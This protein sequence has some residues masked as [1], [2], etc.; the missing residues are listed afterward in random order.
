MRRVQQEADD[1]IALHL[2]LR[3]AQLIAEGM[4]PEHARAEA[5]RRFGSI[6][7]E[8]GRFRHVARRR[9]SRA[10]TR[11]W[12]D[13]VVQDV[14]Y[15]LRTLRRDAGFSLF[16]TLIL[17]LGIGA[18]ATVFSLVNAVLLEPLPFRDPSRLV[19]ISNVGD[20][21]VAEWRLQV[22]HFLDLAAR[23][24]S[25]AGIAGYFAYYGIGDAALS[26]NGATERL[27]RV[28]V[29]CNFFPFLGVTP[30]I[31]R[32]FS[33]EECRFGAPSTV[34]LTAQL[35]RERFAS[36]RSVVG[37]TI[38][39][40][41]A[42][43]TII[44]VLPPAF[45]FGSVFAPGTH[46]DL[47]G[48]YALSDETNRNG[49][50]LA[51]VGRLA[52]GVTVAQASRELVALGTSLTAEF[53]QR[54]T[55]R[56][57]VV[58]LDDR[59]NGKVRPAFLVLASAVAAV[60]LIVMVNLAS[61]QFARMSARQ[62]ELAVRVAL[63]AGRGRLVRQTLTEILMLTAIGAIAGVLLA[64]VGTHLVSRLNAFAIPLLGRTE[65]NGSALG[66]TA[67]VAVATAIFVGVLPAL[68]ASL[69]VH[70]GLADGSRG[71][72]RG[73]AHARL[74]SMLVVTEIAAAC[75]LLV[76]SA[77]LV[78]SFVRVLDVDLG[79]RPQHT[80]MLR[81]DP[82]RSFK[83]NAA[84]AL[85][86]DD[87][88]RR[89]RAIP[90]VSDAAL[91]DLLPFLG[92]R[93]W[94]VAGEGQVYERGHYPEG[95]IR[96][97]SDGYFKTMGIRLRGGRDFTDGDSRGSD[98]VV[99][100]NETL[101]QTLWPHHDAVGEVLLSGDRRLRVVGVVD[102]VR[103]ETLERGYTNEV[104]FPIHQ[105]FERFPLKLV[106]R[107]T[108]TPSELAS[109]VRHAIAAIAPDAVRNQWMPLQDVIDQVV[110]PRRFIVLLLGGFAAFALLLAALGIYALISYGVGQR[111]REIGIRLALGATS[112]AVRA[113]IIRDTLGL[114]AVGMVI[115]LIASAMAVPLLGGMLFGVTWSD[116]ASFGAA[117]VVLGA[118]GAAAGYIPAR[119]A[120]RVDPSTALR[121]G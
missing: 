1:E 5:E 104:Y 10:R 59:V 113:S 118:V 80:A 56:P 112:G 33:A 66:A 94:D 75:V 41:D 88:L 68:H 15:G 98:P 12:L 24:R 62:R 8:R 87:M 58:A 17:A 6:E 93:S 13:S 39:I 100:V 7:E 77:L 48:P 72:T 45:D 49:N 22:N 69:D 86:Y 11:E 42:P 70:G 81:A 9:E 52:P 46:V 76:S 65:V 3:T 54:N 84:A 78:R 114:A 40:N 38:I 53:P 4:S 116:P 16:A 67:L 18:T 97:V 31:G 34:M 82:A 27:T 121:A 50:T 89:V 36:D 90:G 101:A 51:V 92:D 55:I 107:T 20:D 115:G 14:R 21:G 23:S 110:S 25:L 43:A 19:W 35:W 47:F 2:Q 37:R 32:A 120:A 99:I 111:T 79:F 83:S 26:S 96:V 73:S 108:L 102:D 30:I 63:G 91:S 119:R 106:V 64:I 29:T 44:G 60:M 57:R 103:H 95:F 117:V 28:P 109:S 105:M 71:A 74:R 85:Y 61:L